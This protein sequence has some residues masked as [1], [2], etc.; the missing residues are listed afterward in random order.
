M[1]ENFIIGQSW[2]SRLGVSTIVSGVRAE[3]IVAFN[4]ASA[5]FANLEGIASAG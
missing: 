3:N 4:R 5:D 2:A 1:D